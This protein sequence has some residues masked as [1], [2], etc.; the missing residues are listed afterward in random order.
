MFHLVCAGITLETLRARVASL[1][2]DV[3]GLEAIVINL[4]QMR[5]TFVTLDNQVG[6]LWEDAE[7]GRPFLPP[8]GP[9]KDELVSI[10]VLHCGHTFLKLS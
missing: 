7:G 5:K 2:R 6:K 8:N 3:V 10:C 4:D 9:P 1:E